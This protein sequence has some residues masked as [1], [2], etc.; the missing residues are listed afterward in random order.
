MQ[1]AIKEQTKEQYNEEDVQG[2]DLSFHT[3]GLF[4]NLYD[5]L[6][7]FRQEAELCPFAGVVAA[8]VRDAERELTKVVEV[9]TRDIGKI[10]L[11]SWSAAHDLRSDSGPIAAR[12]ITDRKPENRQ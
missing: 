4:D 11:V 2:L 9:I 6:G 7:Q 1:A 12:M 3:E 8:L 10:E 5:A